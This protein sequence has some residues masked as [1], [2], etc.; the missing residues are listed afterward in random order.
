VLYPL[1]GT[2]SLATMDAAGVA[3]KTKVPPERYVDLAI[4]RGDPSD[5]LPGVPGLGEKTAATLVA[6]HPDL[7]ALLAAAGQG[8]LTPR[9]NTALTA[10]ADYIQAM[11]KVAAVATDVGYRIS[12]PHPPDRERL[13]ALASA[14]AIESPVERMLAAMEQAGLADPA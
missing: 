11:R 12:D 10:S 13:A 6:D 4:L 7:D 14:N 1:K 5:G 2:S 3:A 8:R 9:L